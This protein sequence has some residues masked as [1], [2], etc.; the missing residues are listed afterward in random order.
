MDLETQLLDKMRVGASV[1]EIQTLLH[2]GADPN[3]RNPLSLKAPLHYAVDFADVEAVRVLLA[4][5]ADPLAKDLKRRTPKALAEFL[6]NSDDG[7]KYRMDQSNFAEIINLLNRAE[8]ALKEKSTSRKP[9]K[10][11]AGPKR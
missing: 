5:G 11:I 7:Q 3:A 10:P 8:A 6:P 4:A 1:P 2:S 9:G